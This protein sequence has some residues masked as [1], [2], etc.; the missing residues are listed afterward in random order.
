MN[1]KIFLL[2][3]ILILFFDNSFSSNLKF[4][5]KIENDKKLNLNTNLESK[6]KET[7][8]NKGFWDWF[9]FF[10]WNRRKDLDENEVKNIFF[11]LLIFFRL[12]N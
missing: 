10:N 2:F 8:E 5:M 4:S 7:N 3:F 9:D 12:L 6:E 1:M 11:I